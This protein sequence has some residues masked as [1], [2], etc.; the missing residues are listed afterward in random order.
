MRAQRS[1]G[2]QFTK[3]N[4]NDAS[5]DERLIDLSEYIETLIGED[6]WCGKDIEDR[7]V[8]D[9]TDD[10]I[11][12]E[13]DNTEDNSIENILLR[14]RESVSRQEEGFLRRGDSQRNKRQRNQ[15][16]RELHEA[17]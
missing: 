13:L 16:T 15:N 9:L 11:L 2:S 17:A 3:L 1:G 12:K 5:T 14:W 6:D 8:V 4:T 10:D 7:N